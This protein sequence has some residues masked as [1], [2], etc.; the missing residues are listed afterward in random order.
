[1]SVL[2]LH[3]SI[4]LALGLTD[5]MTAQGDEVRWSGPEKDSAAM[6]TA[7]AYIARGDVSDD[8]FIMRAALGCR[9]IVFGSERSAAEVAAIQKGAR[10]AGVERL[11]CV[12]PELPAHLHDTLSAGPLEYVIILTGGGGWLAR[13]KVSLAQVSEAVDAADDKAG[14]LH[15]VIDLTEDEGW[16]RL[17]LSQSER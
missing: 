5:R 6:K 8:D 10:D 13:K 2:L 12:T 17:G 11:V 16:R 7:G 14:P 9:T 1:M 4:D 3:L 15:E